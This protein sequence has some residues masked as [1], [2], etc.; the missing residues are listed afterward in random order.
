MNLPSE[1][2]PMTVPTIQMADQKASEE[3]SKHHT[4]LQS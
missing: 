1:T 4:P 2:D 3:E